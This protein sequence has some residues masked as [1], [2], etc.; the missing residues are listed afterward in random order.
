MS[1]STMAIPSSKRFTISVRQVITLLVVAVGGLGI[2]LLVNAIIGGKCDSRCVIDTLAQTVRVAAPIA[3]AA[4]CGLMC[5]RAAVINI[6]IEGMMLMAAMVGYAID[7]YAF[8]FLKSAGMEVASAGQTARVVGLIGAVASSGLLALM[9]A[10]VSIRFRADQ[11]I[12][13]TVVNIFALGLTGYLY[14]QFLA[15][16]VPTGPGTFPPFDLPLL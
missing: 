9:H 7:I 14:R 3:L 5:E 4:Y 13:G 11:I 2:Y 16:D 12:S 15:Q 10:V 6:G 8:T 1:N